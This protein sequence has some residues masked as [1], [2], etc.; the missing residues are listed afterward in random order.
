MVQI[1]TDVH[2]GIVRVD[3]LSRFYTCSRHD[4]SYVSY[5]GAHLVI[6]ASVKS[7]TV[8]QALELRPPLILT[9]QTG[10]VFAD[11]TI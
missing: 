8:H 3:W 6:G 10:S 5:S 9:F 11:I 4:Q 2:T 1:H 7:G